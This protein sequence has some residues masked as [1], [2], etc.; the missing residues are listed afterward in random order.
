[1]RDYL[2]VMAVS[3]AA[4]AASV[5][6]LRSLSRRVGAMAEPSDR[7]VHAEP[8]PLLGGA[9]LF[10]GLV[11]G[12]ATAA[13]L[14]GLRPVF[15]AP[16]NVLG[17]LLAAAVMFVTGLVDDLRD[18][19]PPAKLAG[20]VLSGSVLTLVGLT[21][22]YL[23]I[24]FL[25]FTVLPPDLSA[26]VSVL[27][28]VGL[29]NAVNLI[30]GLDGLAAGIVAI[31]SFAFFLYGWQLFQVGVVDVTNVGLLIAIVTAGVCLGFLPFNFN[32]ASI[33]M[34][35]SGAL[36]LGLL[37]ASSTI[38][39]GGQSDDPFSGQSWFFFAPLVIPLVILGVPLLDTAFAV[40][41]RAS[42]R[43]GVATADKAH[44]HH[45]LMDLGHGHR[46]AVAILWAWTAL[47]S[48][49]V[50]VPV[51]TDR[52]NGIVPIGLLALGLLLFTAFAPAW[53]RCAPGPD[54]APAAERAQDAVT[55]SVSTPERMIVPGRASVGRPSRT[56]STPDTSTDRTP[57]EPAKRRSVP[58]GRSSTI[59][60]ISESTTSGSNR[61]R[62]AWAPSRMTPRSLRPNSSAGTVV[63]MRTASSTVVSLRPRRQSAKKRVG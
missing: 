49:F 62:S 17:V 26:L 57:T 55:V 10:V 41:R 18:V 31:A 32:P 12:I 1:M 21:V 27:W 25:G 3:V 51:Y 33:F 47:L 37:L 48:A 24:P 45:R 20:M 54:L 11:V 22:I 14:P 2:I 60:S 28:V 15:E 43:S 52:G 6:P 50:L 38:A 23:R 19:S 53:A 7:S 4:T 30:D 16:S 40:I 8:T 44:L 9:A 13:L 63:I 29:A 58:P 36:L 35:D 61:T 59:E 34:G 42:R 5:P 46:R 56:T 39:V